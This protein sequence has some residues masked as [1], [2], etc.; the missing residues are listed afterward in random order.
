MHYLTIINKPTANYIATFKDF[1]EDDINYYLVMEYIGDYTL[2]DFAEKAHK[3]IKNQKLKMKDYKKIVKYLMWQ[4]SM[5]LYMYSFLYVL[6]INVT[7]IY[8]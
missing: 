5:I 8:L 4:L 7:L 1:F 6:Y 3:Y 2:A